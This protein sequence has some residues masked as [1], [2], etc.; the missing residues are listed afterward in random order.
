VASGSQ[1]WG[2]AVILGFLAVGLAGLTFVREE[3]GGTSV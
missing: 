3:R 2:M 1:Q